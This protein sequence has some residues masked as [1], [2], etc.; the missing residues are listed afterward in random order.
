MSTLR[1]GFTLVEILIVVVILGILAAI[2][3]PQ[4]ASAS[5]DAVKSAL[6]SQMQTITAQIELY[7]VQNTGQ[8]PHQA[9]A[10]A[11]PVGGGTHNGWGVLVEDQFLKD[12]PNNGFTRSSDV[13]VVA[14]AAVGDAVAGGLAA[15]AAPA[16]DGSTTGWLY[17]PQLGSIYAN[18]FNADLNLLSNEA[19]F[20]VPTW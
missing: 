7:R 5:Q 12:E 15:G 10:P 6:Q 2:V 20:A 17:N 16:A 11:V 18:G 4:F 1:K 13:T 19:N 3:V 8:L 14:A 9:V